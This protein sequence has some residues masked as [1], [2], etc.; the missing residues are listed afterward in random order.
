M[1]SPAKEIFV[2]QLAAEPRKFD[3]PGESSFHPLWPRSA[4]DFQKVEEEVKRETRQ[5]V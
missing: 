2:Y 4:E 1:V 3:F 5:S